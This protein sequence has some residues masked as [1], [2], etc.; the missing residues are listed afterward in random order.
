MV[1]STM[2]GT[3]NLKILQTRAYDK[4]R[5]RQVC[6]LTTLLTEGE[7][8]RQRW[9][10]SLKQGCPFYVAFTE[11]KDDSDYYR[12]S[13]INAGHLCARD[14]DSVDCYHQYRKEDSVVLACAAT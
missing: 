10:A 12:C 1:G 4:R 14:L 2:T 9:G 5:F 7:K 3:S 11:A 6:P 8:I 13:G